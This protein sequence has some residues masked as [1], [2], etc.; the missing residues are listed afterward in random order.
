MWYYIISCDFL[1]F[2]DRR[3]TVRFFFSF[4]LVEKNKLSHIFFFNFIYFSGWSYVFTIFIFYSRLL[5]KLVYFSFG[6]VELMI[7]LFWFMLS[8]FFFLMCFVLGYIIMCLLLR[9][10]CKLYSHISCVF[11]MYLC[12]KIYL[13]EIYD[14]T[15]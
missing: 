14:A 2:D 12:S 8:S 5:L 15:F 1:E 11:I 6:D 7:Y 3:K 4:L 10:C 9:M 13:F